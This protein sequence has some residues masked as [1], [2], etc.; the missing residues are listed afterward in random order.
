MRGFGILLVVLAMGC[1]EESGDEDAGPP[2]PSVDSGPAGVDAGP[3]PRDG[4]VGLPDTGTFDAGDTTDAGYPD[5]GPPGDAGPPPIVPITF[6]GAGDIADCSALGLAGIIRDPHEYTA[7]LFAHYAP[8]TPIFALGD[9]VYSNGTELEYRTCYSRAW[10]MHA[11]R[12]YP[13]PGNHDYNT[14]DAQPYHDFFGGRFGAPRRGWWSRDLGDWHI[15]GLDSNCGDVP[16]LCDTDSEQ[17]NWLR[18]DLAA[19]TA[20]CTL[21]MWHH[22][23]W[24]SDRAG[25]NPSSGYFMDELYA[26]GADLVLVGHAHNYER[27]P[28]MN[29]S[30]EIDLVGGMRQFVVGTGGASLRPLE[31]MSA[32]SEL[33][34]DRTH[35]IM[36]LTLHADRYEWSFIPT[37]GSFTDTG[38]ELCH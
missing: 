16:G 23:R 32:Q 20:R 19:S 9:L 10:G 3:P 22:P 4:M 35:G 28:P 14:D 15:V 13:V 24:S 12:T 27:F 30:G 37:E 29:P 31:I 26:A 25:D 2:P 36:E 8:D 1:G 34:Y 7:D 6:I 21:A 38:M 17:L 18:A 5:A 33:F 11:A